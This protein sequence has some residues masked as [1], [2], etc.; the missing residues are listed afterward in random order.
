MKELFLGI[1]KLETPNSVLKI[2]QLTKMNFQKILNIIIAFFAPPLTVLFVEGFSLQFFINL[3][4]TILMFV[5]GIAHALFV[6]IR[7]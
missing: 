6:A 5:A 3:T 4:L 1:E 7:A 2:A